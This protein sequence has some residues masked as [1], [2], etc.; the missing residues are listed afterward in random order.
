MSNK[1]ANSS[2]L[3]DV[4]ER[5]DQE[6]LSQ[7]ALGNAEAGQTEDLSS[8]NDLLSTPVTTGTGGNPA[9]AAPKSLIVHEDE[10][11]VD[12]YEEGTTGADTEEK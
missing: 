1:D 11:G 6:Q 4:N 12:R 9:A 7:Q 2:P 5:K 8:N 10:S 3:D